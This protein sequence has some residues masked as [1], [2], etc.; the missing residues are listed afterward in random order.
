M[1]RTITLAAAVAVASNT[2]IAQIDLG[3]TSPGG[4]D[5]SYEVTITNLT[6]GQ[7]FTPQLLVAHPTAIALFEIGAAA[8]EEL[9]I[10]AEGGN[11]VPLMEL[12]I[13]AGAHAMTIDGL[14]APGA[15]TSG[16]I[17]AVE[18]DVLS[19]AAM[20]IPTN[21]TFV[22]LDSM[23]LPAEGSVTYYLKAYDAGTE[24]NDQLCRNIP[25][26]VCGG[27]GESAP[28]MGD[29]GFV[30]VSNGFHNL[31]GNALKPENYDWR[32]PVAKVT[33]TAM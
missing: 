7:T 28:A 13:G 21:D 5:G 12:A 8:T 20:L 29:E 4:G 27:E 6:P 33:V 22:A 15:S 2:A 25:G 1:F 14:L 17:D 31:R 16:I 3:F 26:P 19:I 18:G 32:N 9:A 24:E 11:T 23:P 10:L 30:H